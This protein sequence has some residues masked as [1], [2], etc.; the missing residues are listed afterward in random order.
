[1]WFSTIF[2]KECLNNFNVMMNYV[3][4]EGKNW[5]IELF[6]VPFLA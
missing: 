2:L 1:M 4:C 5:K 6:L 3:L